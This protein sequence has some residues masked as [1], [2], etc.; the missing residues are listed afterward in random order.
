MNQLSE[1]GLS[2]TPYPGLR[3]FR[4]DE[5]DIFFGREEQVDQLLAKLETC[6]FL[7]VVGVSGCGKSSLVRA[8]MLSALE[9]GFLA[10]AGPRWHIIEMRPGGHP[11]ANL[12]RA[13]LRGETLNEE[14]KRRPDAE[15]FVHA[16][17]RRGPLGLVELM[18]ESLQPNRSNLLL[19]VDQFEEIFRFHRHGDANEATAF[20]AL[21]LESARQ[22]QVP[23][24]VVITMR[25]DF[26]GDCSIFLQLPEAIN[27]GQFL[28]PRLTREQ[29]RA[30]VAGPAAAFGAEVEGE[31]VNHILND[32]GSNPDQLPLMQHALMRVWNRTPEANGED[33]RTLTVAEY[34]A[35]GGLRNALSHHADELYEG[36]TPEDRRV[37]EALFRC[38]SERGGDG[39]DI[40]RPIPLSVAAEAAQVPPETIVRI[41]EVFREPTCNFLT[42]PAGVPLEADTV[43]DISHESLIRQWRR[44]TQW[45]QTEAE[46]A[47]IFR[48]LSETAILWEAN[49]AALWHTPDLENA[50]CW[51]EREKPNAAWAER[52]GGGFADSMAFLDASVETHDRRM[53]E[54][55]ERQERERELLQNMALAEK[56]RADDAEERRRE[57]SRANR[58]LRR[59]AVAALVAGV[60]AVV[61][62]AIAFWLYAEAR[63]EQEQANAARTDAERASIRAEDARREAEEARKQAEKAELATA[64]ASNEAFR[65]LAQ[66]NLSQLR[67]LWTSSEPGR[68]DEALRLLRES[69]KLHTTAVNLAVKQ[70]Q[71]ERDTTFAFWQRLTPQLRDEAARWL[72]ST[73]LQQV[74]RTSIPAGGMYYAY[75]EA[76]SVFSP[77]LKLVASFDPSAQR[78][79]LQLTDS[80]SGSVLRTLPFPADHPLQPVAL[81]FSSDGATLLVAG[82]SPQSGAIEYRSTADLQ[83]KKTVPLSQDKAAISLQANGRHDLRGNRYLYSG[84]NGTAV[85]DATTGAQLFADSQVRTII[86]LNEAEDQLLTLDARQTAVA[87]SLKDGKTVRETPLAI[88][89]TNTSFVVSSDGKWLAAFLWP[90]YDGGLQVRPLALFNL[91]TG[92]K[93][94]DVG[95]ST[96]SG[97]YFSDRIKAAFH[98][99][100]A[101]LAALDGQTLWLVS[102]P[103]GG[104]LQQLRAAEGDMARRAPTPYHVRF[105]PRGDLAMTMVR[106]NSGTGNSTSLVTQVWDLALATAPHLTAWNGPAQ[107]FRFAGDD[108]LAVAGPVM[109]ASGIQF[110]TL[111]GTGLWQV[112]S[113]AA[114]G[115]FDP[116][117]RHFVHVLPDRFDVYEAATGKLLQSIGRKTSPAGMALPIDRTYHWL[118]GVDRTGATPRL[119]LFDVSNL[120][121]TATLLDNPAIV[122]A[123]VLDTTG[124]YA[125]LTGTQVVRGRGAQG[126]GA[127]SV[128]RCADGKRLLDLPDALQDWWITDSGYFLSRAYDQNRYQI[129]VH[130]LKTGRLVLEQPVSPRLSLNNRAT[131]DGPER[132]AALMEQD[133]SRARIFVWPFAAGKA[134]KQ[135][136]REYN[137]PYSSRVA[138]TADRLMIVAADFVPVGPGTVRGRWAVHLWDTQGMELLRTE[139]HDPVQDIHVSAGTGRAVVSSQPSGSGSSCEVWDLQTGETLAAFP[140]YFQGLSPDSRFVLLAS[141][142]WIDLATMTVRQLDLTSKKSRQ[143]VQGTGFQE[144]AFSS[145]SRHVVLITFA[146]P[147]SAR[148]RIFDLSAAGAEWTPAEPLVASS[149]VI[150]PDGKVVGLFENK[151]AD[152]LHLFSLATRRKLQTINLR[153]GNVR[154]DRPFLNGVAPRIVFSPDGK[155]VAAVVANQFRL[156]TAEQPR[157]HTA[158]PRGG[159]TT[160]VNTIAVSPDG[161]L[162]ASA[163]SDGT[164]GFWRARDGRSLGMLEDGGAGPSMVLRRVAFSPRGNLIAYRK[165]NGE[166]AVWK[167]APPASE[168]GEVTAVFLWANARGKDGPLT[169][170]PDGKTLAAGD[171]AGDVRLFE[172]ETGRIAQWLKPQG[173]AAAVQ[174]LAFAPDGKWLAAART[175]VVM[176]WDVETGSPRLTWDARQGR[177]HD[178]GFSADGRLLATAGRDVRL[179][180][181][182]TG[183]PRLT[184]ERQASSVRQVAFSPSGR[185][186]AAVVDDKAIVV[187]ELA[188]LLDAV[189]NL[190]L[191]L[192]AETTPAAT[193]AEPLWVPE[194]RARIDT[195]NELSELLGQLAR[196][197]AGKDQQQVAALLTRLIEKEPDNEAWH[198][199]RAELYQRLGEWPAMAEDL[200]WAL[201]RMPALPNPQRAQYLGPLYRALPEAYAALEKLR[202]NDSLL[203]LTR[204][205]D[206]ALQGKWQEAQA[207]FASA[208]PNLSNPPPSEEWFEYAA[209]CLICGDRKAYQEHVAWMLK[210][211]G[212]PKDEPRFFLYARTASLGADSGVDRAQVVQWAERTLNKPQPPWFY[213][214]AG[215]AY[216]R[217][218]QFDKAR[219]SLEQSLEAT[220]GELAMVNR[221]ALGIIEKKLGNDKAAREQLDLARERRRLVESNRTGGYVNVGSLVDWLELNALLPELEGMLDGRR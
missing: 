99:T 148:A 31:L 171:A 26:L 173:T 73:T 2:L 1:A 89:P 19:L 191:K 20:V 91:V 144:A 190:G 58:R 71:A 25:S 90:R 150:S 10:S 66:S 178:L 42:P 167:W 60:A 175:E 92:E 24:Y 56:Q 198:Q 188:D 119:G 97:N 30:A 12:A 136:P 14:W 131:F 105:S 121:W 7:A 153:H 212:Q 18:R 76:C 195:E 50:L 168:D 221:L 160:T 162:L 32:I 215:L 158:L 123:V 192:S 138:L 172:A 15:A 142:K 165:D 128:W 181:A 9:G 127:T 41:V 49:Q 117:G 107:D 93:V 84:T 34:Q 98:P 217:A 104:V 72:S 122:P 185:R 45:V 163:G 80:Q 38:L 120:K 210:Q 220:S 115:N 214:V 23:I 189:D 59:R 77:D 161:R 82:T 96:Y 37:A 193:T 28:I 106:E 194:A 94:A 78:R 129:R 154:P 110:Q 213:H 141:G 132:T 64:R 133:A 197:E 124:T 126:T 109:Q 218:G 75:N 4:R 139:S 54:E 219:E 200:S 164:V 187:T 103:G 211:E 102:V 169:F 202:P 17:L 206:L 201:G 183:A 53:R 145:D 179:W 21:L 125:V 35:V 27:D 205:R 152:Q 85:W 48:R 113:S 86:G 176:V 3:P 204:G 62:A 101:L 74:R 137:D 180:D 40:R 6:R 5:A 135:V 159:H 156:A 51:R 13:L 70:D 149:A 83:V 16:V 55:K 44:M 43:L 155:G 22:Q 199:R 216:C 207:A 177:I 203:P 29:C 209:L 184:V 81:G 33:E 196:A 63:A 8:G 143:L 39:R 52:Y 140:E 134:M 182:A 11:L 88:D 114:E 146:G 112:Q 116:T 208:L 147:D 108:T 170:S 174:G 130:D 57:Q 186:L 46:S 68:Q 166:I 67:S 47:A 100:G 69:G 87:V 36:L 111:Q 157:A 118:A 65:N 95:L 151:G 61:L 79:E